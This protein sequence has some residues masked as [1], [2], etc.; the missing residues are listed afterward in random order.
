MQLE[1]TRPAIQEL[2]LEGELDIFQAAT[3]EDQIRR[4]TSLPGDVLILSFQDVRYV[5]SAIVNVLVS[6][7]NQLGE[8][9]QIVVPADGTVRRILRV[10]RLEER[11]DVHSTLESARA[12]ARR[13]LELA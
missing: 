12:R 8:R 3:V 10:L 4:R 6:Y 7:R 1:V 2:A 9:L 13:V 11:L 5:S